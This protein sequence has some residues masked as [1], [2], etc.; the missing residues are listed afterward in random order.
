MR[1]VKIGEL[2][3][4]RLGFGCYAIGGAYGARGRSGQVH[5]A[6]GPSGRTQ[7]GP[8]QSR[9][10]PS[11]RDAG[12]WEALIRRAFDLGVTFFDTAE[13][14]GPA[15][16]ILGRAV[17]PFRDR[18]IIATKVGVSST[19]QRDASPAR[20]LEGCENSLRRLGTS[21]I[22]LYQIHFDD[23]ATPVAETVGALEKL[24]AQ[25]KI[26][27]YG[28]GHLP[29]AKVSEYARLGRPASALFELSAVARLARN[30]L[31]P[32]LRRAGMA[33]IAFSPTGRGLL[34]GAIGPDT[35]FEPGDIR[36]LDPLFSRE[37]FTSGL[38][39]KDRLAEIGRKRGH[40]PAQVAIAWVL[41]QPGVTMA[42]TGPTNP[43]H[44]E[45]NLA[46]AGWEFPADDLAGLEAFLAEED[47]RVR[48]A[49]LASVR[50]ILSRPL[51]RDGDKAC[52]DL[53]YVLETAIQY[54]LA[55]E[56][57]AMPLVVRVLALR[58]QTGGYDP[59]LED[60]RQELGG[61]LAAR[62]RPH[63]P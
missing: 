43:A 9:G 55:T 24:R 46:A 16:E 36:A 35:R 39:V 40:T 37:R 57:E 26:R 29:L 44:L 20:V 27:E 15:E 53:V 52:A 8:V 60:V 56:E 45:E 34:T 1:Q 18:V 2:S 11:A 61:L 21:W 31:L 30:D 50:D 10:S 32:F 12:R 33:G 41:A 62:Y 17:A 7:P 14:Y 59:G 6:R 13:V 48:G 38:R 23:P 28:V 4:S 58:K 25:G 47:E 19:G 51:P 49:S 42:L 3:S 22:D 5:S 54:G 63:E